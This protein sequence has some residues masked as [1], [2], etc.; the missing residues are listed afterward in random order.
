MHKKWVVRRYIFLHT[1]KKLCFFMQKPQY[2]V[3]LS[4]K[5]QEL[6]QNIVVLETCILYAYVVQYNCNKVVNKLHSNKRYQLLQVH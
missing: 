1:F 2:I 4:L 3:F 5:I 6:A